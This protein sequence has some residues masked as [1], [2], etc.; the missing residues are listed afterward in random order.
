[1][2]LEMKI[3]LRLGLRYSEGSLGSLA[4]SSFALHLKSS[5]TSGLLLLQNF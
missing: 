3:R 4:D 2:E 5:I 1:M